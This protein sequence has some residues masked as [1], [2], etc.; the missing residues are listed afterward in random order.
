MP[1]SIP[2]ALS[3]SFSSPSPSGDGCGGRGRGDT[4]AATT[5]RRC[6]AAR[7]GRGRGMDRSEEAVRF[8]A[9]VVEDAAGGGG[10]RGG[11]EAAILRSTKKSEA[12][13]RT[14]ARSETWTVGHGSHAT[15]FQRSFFSFPLRLLG[16]ARFGTQFRRGRLRSDSLSCGGWRRPRPGPAYHVPLWTRLGCA[17]AE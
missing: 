8:P 13:R 1:P 15:V 3:T 16:S 10:G 7:R 12:T 5:A 6:A 4:D 17:K 11:E 9:S 14:S 2:I